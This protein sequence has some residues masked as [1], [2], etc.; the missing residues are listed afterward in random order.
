MRWAP[1]VSQTVGGVSARVRGFDDAFTLEEFSSTALPVVWRATGGNP[2]MSRS[3]TSYRDHQVEHPSTTT[4]SS[5]SHSRHDAAYADTNADPDIDVDMDVDADAVTSLPHSAFDNHSVRRDRAMQHNADAGRDGDMYEVDEAERRR[6][7]IATRLRRRQQR[8]RAVTDVREP[9]TCSGAFPNASCG[10]RNDSDS[11]KNCGAKSPDSRLRQAAHAMSTARA[12]AASLSSP[13]YQVEGRRRTMDCGDANS[14]AVALTTDMRRPSLWALIVHARR[15]QQQIQQQMQNGSG[16]NSSGG[17][18]MARRM[19][20]GS[21]AGGRRRGDGNCTTG[22]V[23]ARRGRAGRRRRGRAKGL[24]WRSGGLEQGLREE[25]E[26]EAVEN[27][28]TEVGLGGGDGRTRDSVGRRES[29]SLFRRMMG[30]LDR[31]AGRRPGKA[32]GG[33]DSERDVDASLKEGQGGGAVLDCSVSA[34][35]NG[36]S[37]EYLTFI[38]S[39]V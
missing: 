32:G 21:D 20:R 4:T 37:D 8:L 19:V 11:D 7:H 14:F 18:G 23:G 39:V 13:L 2:C 16:G 38:T 22:P 9:V 29:M 17:G 35:P 36:D 34:A 28:A 31:R 5:H 3:S 33:E 15:Q 24:L 6:K 10:H 27:C 26:E 25:H 12:A 1:R 30:H